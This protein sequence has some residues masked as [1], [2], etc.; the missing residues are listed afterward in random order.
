M[1]GIKMPRPTNKPV[2]SEPTNNVPATETKDDTMSETHISAPATETA[3]V[4]LTSLMIEIADGEFLDFLTLP[5]SSMVA[6]AE[7]GW[8]RSVAERQTSARTKAKNLYAKENG[9]DKVSE[10]TDKMVG[11]IFWEKADDG[12]LPPRHAEY[13]A[14]KDEL[15]AEFKDAAIAGK[16]ERSAP[17]ETQISKDRNEAARRLMVELYAEVDDKNGVPRRQVFLSVAGPKKATNEKNRK[18]NDAKVSAL[19]GNEALMTKFAAR[20]D[21]HMAAI[22]KERDDAATAAKAVRTATVVENLDDLATFEE[23]PLAAE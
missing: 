17:T 23:T 15:A 6:L 22:K 16:I 13:D 10:V 18:A 11:P 8:S 12:S 1:K 21:R 5:V 14:W 19:L 20:F 9:I 7:K 4:A 2:L 3:P